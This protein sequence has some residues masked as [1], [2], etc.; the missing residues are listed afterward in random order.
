MRLYFR[1]RVFIDWL[2]SILFALFVL[3]GA[4][5]DGLKRHF[6][7]ADER[8]YLTVATVSATLLGFS[9]ASASFLISHTRSAGM[10]VLRKSKSFYELISLLQS[11]L[12]RFF[13]LLIISLICFSLNL[14][15]FEW[16]S[17]IFI[18]FLLPAI[19]SAIALIWTVTAILRLTA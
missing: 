13:V 12:W 19:L 3:F 1:N 14:S 6:I 17:V 18:L 15:R 8:I 11:T 2:V 10:D 5:H 16:G 9:L 4:N 7:V